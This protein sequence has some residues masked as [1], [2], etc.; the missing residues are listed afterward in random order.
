MNYAKILKR[1]WDILW[2]YKTL[3][4]FGII[5][6]LTSGGSFPGT[7]RNNSRTNA[8]HGNFQSGLPLELKEAFGDIC[9]YLN[10]AFLSENRNALI[11]TIIAVILFILLISILLTIGRYVSQ[12]A[13]IKMVDTNES[14]GEKVNWQQGFRLGWSPQAWQLFL[15]DLLI[16]L[17]FTIIAV[18][19]MGVS[20]LPLIFSTMANHNKPSGLSIVA[21]LGLFFLILIILAIIGIVLSSFMEIIY[22]ECV[23][24]RNGVRKSIRNGWKKVVR[25]IKDVILMW[26]ILIGVRLGVILVSMPLGLFLM[27]IGLLIG[28]GTGGILYFLNNMSAFDGWI[29]AAIVG[30]ALLLIILSLPMLFLRGLEET[31][32]SSAWTLTYRELGELGILQ[33][34][35]PSSTDNGETGDV[36]Q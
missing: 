24:K 30:G 32:I 6:A 17:P 5:L 21:F 13:L 16:Y 14:S 9:R 8:F 29:I 34:E 20:F 27:T 1:A 22:R 26:L 15:I 12:T 11:G 19:L 23:L 31:Y 35:L 36:K 3:W 7:A 4:V 33:N 2:S 18:I 25:N 28:G 10:W